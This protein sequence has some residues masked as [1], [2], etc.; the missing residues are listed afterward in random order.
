M[1][2]IKKFFPY[3]IIIGTLGLVLFAIFGM[4]TLVR[5][6]HVNGFDMVKF[7]VLGYLKNINIASTELPP[8]FNSILPTRTYQEGAGLDF[9]PALAN[10][11]AMIFDWLYFPINFILYILRWLAYIWKLF[12]SILG[13][14]MT[15]N[16]VNGEK[17]YDSQVIFVLQTVIEG[18]MIPYI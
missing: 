13:W 4:N 17:V 18:L 16:I 3:L 7:D 14:P 8:A 2:V 6:E 10:N 9:F 12:F 5:I 15:Y 1:L 11:L